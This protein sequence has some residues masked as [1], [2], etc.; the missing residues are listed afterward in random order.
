MKKWAPVGTSSPLSISL[1]CHGLIR[2]DVDNSS[3]PI[4]ARRRARATL[5]PNHLASAAFLGV[6]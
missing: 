1:R 5:C 4:S 6:R 2:A 3:I